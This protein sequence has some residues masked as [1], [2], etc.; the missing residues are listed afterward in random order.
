MKEIF[1]S[2]SRQLAEE[3]ISSG[4]QKHNVS[5]G[6]TRETILKRF[7]QE[8]LPPIYGVT[9][10]EIVSDLGR[11]KQVDIILYNANE[12]RGF[13]LGDP[14]IKIIQAESV[15]AIIEVKSKIN[16]NKLIEGINNI[17]ASIDICPEPRNI[18]DSP[19]K[20]FTAIFAYDLDKCSLK[21]LSDNLNDILIENPRNLVNLVC[22]LNKGIIHID[23]EFIPHQYIPI[24]NAT[25]YGPFPI[26]EESLYYF[27]NTLQSWR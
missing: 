1:V 21:S 22:I 7:L 6:T 11:S 4:S 26:G 9:S 5:K 10:G 27:W 25:K 15:M 17:L 12:T 19:R 23:N 2:K 14:N 13:S 18:I 16:K 24:Y 20:P 3:Y 8:T